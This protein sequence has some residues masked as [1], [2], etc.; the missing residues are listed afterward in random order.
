MYV[1]VLLYQNDIYSH[2]QFDSHN[3]T[4][5]ALLLG[6]KGLPFLF[7]LTSNIIQG[8]IQAH[9]LLSWIKFWFVW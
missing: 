1:R 7:K 9:F 8:H 2:I 4:Y 5:Y 6:S 3:H